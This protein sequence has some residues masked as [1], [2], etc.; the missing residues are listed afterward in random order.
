ML[1]FRLIFVTVAIN[2]GSSSYAVSPGE[3]G[4]ILMKSTDFSSGPGAAYKRLSTL[5]EGAEARVLTR[6]GSWTKIKLF[7]AGRQG[8]VEA[9]AIEAVGIP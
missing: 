4:V 8:W 9:R 1:V 2:F 3:R 5:H 6:R 7:D